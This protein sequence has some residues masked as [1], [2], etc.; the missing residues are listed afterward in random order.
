MTFQIM[1]KQ[2]ITE[3]TLK[4]PSKYEPLI[5]MEIG[6]CVRLENKQ[7]ADAAYMFLYR[8]N[9][10]GLRRQQKDGSYF[11]WRIF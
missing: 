4:R 8:N 9:F 1:K 7:E 11:L 10:G 5:E 3:R 2:P 6:D